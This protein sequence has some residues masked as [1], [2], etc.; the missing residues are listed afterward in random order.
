MLLLG[1]GS[2]PAGIELAG[3]Y[4]A[5]STPVTEITELS[6]DN[7]RSVAATAHLMPY[8]ADSCRGYFIWLDG[9][10]EAA[11][12]VLLKPLEDAP[13]W[14]RFV[15]AAEKTRPL[16]T[17]MSRCQVYPLGSP[18]GRELPGEQPGAAETRAKV[19][20]AVKAA[21]TGQRDVLSSAVRDWGPQHGLVLGLWA[22]EAASG[23]WARFGPDF[24]PGVTAAQA[25]RLLEVLTRYEGAR[26]AAVVA[27]E[28]TFLTV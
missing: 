18:Y 24:A 4:G 5:G 16:Q 7:A 26:T 10:S 2:F 11:Q 21:R 20:T 8:G 23:A 1:P 28:K 6:M 9:A 15:L 22:A 27:L 14:V 12:Q 19:A 3:R 13:G 25:L 17:V